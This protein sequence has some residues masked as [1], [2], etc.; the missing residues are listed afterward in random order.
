MS[1]MRN[2]LSDPTPHDGDNEYLQAL[3]NPPP[4]APLPVIPPTVPQE[5]PAAPTHAIVVNPVAG[6]SL[7]VPLEPQLTNPVA[8]SGWGE[9]PVAPPVLTPITP[10][11]VPIPPNQPG[12]VPLPPREIVHTY[13]TIPVNTKPSIP[14]PPLPPAP[15]AAPAFL[16]KA[17]A[18]TAPALTE[19][20]TNEA[21]EQFHGYAEYYLQLKAQKK[22]H[23]DSVK[24]IN[25]QMLILEGKIKD[26]LVRTK[27]P[28]LVHKAEGSKDTT[29]FGTSRNLSIKATSGLPNLAQEILRQAGASI[30]LTPE[31]M[32]PMLD[33]AEAGLISINAS[34]LAKHVREL[35]HDPTTNQWELHK[36]ASVPKYL[37]DQVEFSEFDKLRVT[38]A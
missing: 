28:S 24:E 17:V 10:Q 14:P 36:K 25:P 26:Q 16:E 12:A 18:E 1:N 35:M 2:L 23:E 32:G 31:H 19:E 15:T 5:I 11:A 4:L 21:I 3:G 8:P 9:K 30:G 29:R 20:Q 34:T 33:F 7:G 37:I 22:S 13:P 27:Q 6:Q 38:K